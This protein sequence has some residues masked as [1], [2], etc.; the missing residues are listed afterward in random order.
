MS[1]IVYIDGNSQPMAASLRPRYPGAQFRAAYLWA[2]EIE[3]AEAVYAPGR[4][5]I[6]AAYAARGIPEFAPSDAG[7]IKAERV[8]L[9]RPDAIVI[10]C[11]GPNLAKNWHKALTAAGSKRMV[12]GVNT[13]VCYVPCDLWLALDGHRTYGR[14]EVIGQPAKLLAAD[15]IGAAVGPWVDLRELV[16]DLNCGSYTVVGALQIAEAIGAQVVVTVGMDWQ[17]GAGIDGDASNRD[18]SRFAAE[19]DQAG[20]VIRRMMAKGITVCRIVTEPDDCVLPLPALDRIRQT[21]LAG[22][23]IRTGTDLAMALRERMDELMAIP[24]VGRKVIAAWAESL[25]VE[26]PND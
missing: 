13:A 10:A 16:P 20:A 14:G 23:G 22:I 26:L 2:G 3:P 12:I 25:G 9:S 15:Q 18:A 19:A 21:Q 6:V 7:Q 24:R 17:P 4:A 8:T 5:D 11:P 1:I